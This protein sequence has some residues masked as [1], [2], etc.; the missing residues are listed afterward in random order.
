VLDLNVIGR[1]R[2]LV[3]AVTENCGS[4]CQKLDWKAHKSMCSNLKKFSKELQPYDKAILVIWQ[5]INSEKMEDIRSLEHL[6]S[7]TDLQL[8]NQVTETIYFERKDGQ[9]INDY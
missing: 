9:R 1:Q 4:D 7:Y 2:V 5:V 3:Q 6:Q 8:G